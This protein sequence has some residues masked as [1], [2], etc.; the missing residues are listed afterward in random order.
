[1]PKKVEEYSF[2]KEVDSIAPQQALR[3]IDEAFQSFF[4]S[5]GEGYPRY[6]ATVSQQ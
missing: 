1:M 3:H 4:T 6:K 2:L 5:Q